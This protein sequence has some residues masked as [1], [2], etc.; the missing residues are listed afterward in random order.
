MWKDKNPIFLMQT[1]QLF[2][3]QTLP[4]HSAPVAGL[5]AVIFTAT[6]MLF[7]HGQSGVKQLKSNDN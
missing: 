1:L 4:V 2:M 7:L 5:G 3:G 6:Q